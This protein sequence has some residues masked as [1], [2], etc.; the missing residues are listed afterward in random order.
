MKSRELA[1]RHA[2]REIA[3]RW[4]ERKYGREPSELELARVM[5]AM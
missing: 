4:F 5:A 1:A 3:W 2:D